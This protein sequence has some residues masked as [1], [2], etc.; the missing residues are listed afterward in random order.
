MQ[1]LGMR[2]SSPI[3]AAGPSRTCTGF[4]FHPLSRN[5]KNGSY[6]TGK[7]W[8]RQPDSVDRQEAG[9]K[10]VPGK[11]VVD[12]A[13]SVYFMQDVRGEGSTETGK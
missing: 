9:G 11:G 4:P 10:R 8:Q 6:L 3:T 7:A 13:V 2:R 12:W 5:L 1:W